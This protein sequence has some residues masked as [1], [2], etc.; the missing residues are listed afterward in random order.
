MDEIDKALEPFDQHDAC[1]ACGKRTDGLMVC[2]F[3]D[4]Y[5]TQLCPDCMVDSGFC[6]MCG[7]WM[8]KNESIIMP[9]YCAECQNEIENNSEDYD[10]PDE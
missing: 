7:N 2:Y 1:H 10:Y 6:F 3:D 5:S 9:G 8:D 4:G